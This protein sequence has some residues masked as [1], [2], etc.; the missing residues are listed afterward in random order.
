MGKVF[1]YIFPKCRIME[2]EGLWC[3]GPDWTGGFPVLIYFVQFPHSAITAKV[4]D[5]HF[6]KRLGTSD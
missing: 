2:L 4:G 5:L 3:H 6:P 1:V